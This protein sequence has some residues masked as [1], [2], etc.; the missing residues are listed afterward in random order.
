MLRSEKRKLRNR[1]NRRIAYALFNVVN[2]LLACTTFKDAG[3]AML[4]IFAIVV[5]IISYVAIFNYED[6]NV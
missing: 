5:G 1:R 4:A 6:N 3:F 2:V